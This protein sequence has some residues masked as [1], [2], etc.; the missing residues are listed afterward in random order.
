M[1]RHAQ[2]NNIDHKDLRIDTRHS[3]TLGDDVG[4]AATFPAEFRD[5]QAYYPILFRK[6][7]RG[8]L[9]PIALLGFEEGRN[10]FL[11]GER[12]DA[13]YLPLAI[14]RQ[15]FLIGRDG[16]DMTVHI[17]LDNPRVG[18]TAGQPL[19]RE[20]GGNT[21]YLD[22]IAS[23]L[24]T[25]HNGLERV[26][27]FVDALLALDLL[28]SFALDVELDDGSINRLAGYYTINEDRLRGLDAEALGPLH[29]SGHLEPI[30]MAVASIS[31]FR[32]LIDRM[33]RS[34][35]GGR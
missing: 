8:A 18:S 2:V 33:N 17:D 31:N 3:A 23:V 34:R 20:H 14:E 1:P 4:F 24:L 10:L 7:A 15:P 30:F 19:F 12:W 21:E 27:A 28:E 13:H 29:A 25:L 35:A 16:G 11:D 32:S 22:R 26:P 5:L 9:S 6:D